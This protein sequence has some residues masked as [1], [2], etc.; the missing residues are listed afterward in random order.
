M[1]VTNPVR[2]DFSSR[3]RWPCAFS[4]QEGCRC[5]AGE[6]SSRRPPPPPTIHRPSSVEGSSRARSSP[7][8]AYQHIG[9]ALV[10]PRLYRRL[11]VRDRRRRKYSSLGPAVRRASRSAGRRVRPGSRRQPPG[12]RPVRRKAEPFPGA[13]RAVVVG[14]VHTDETHS[15]NTAPRSLRSL[16]GF[17]ST[18]IP[19][20]IPPS[21]NSRNFPSS[22]PRPGQPSHRP[23]PSRRGERVRSDP[24]S[25][26][27]GNEFHQ[28]G[29]LLPS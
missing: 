16:A 26:G 7:R 27:R 21:P 10:S 11:S 3:P 1:L 12:Q 24:R 8:P 29:S 5:G 6:R 13:T 23:D 19:P 4:S 14:I 22:L 17:P 15:S 2:I 9:K 28:Q 18:L 20:A 25:S